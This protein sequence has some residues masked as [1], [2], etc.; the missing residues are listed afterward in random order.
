MS[1]NFCDADA[2]KIID[3]VEDRRL[4]SL[5]KYFSR[6]SRNARLNV[7]NIIIDMYTPYILHIKTM[8]PN[9]NIITD[10]FHTVQLI[11]RALNKTR[12]SLMNKDKLHYNKLKR[13][14]KLLL[15]DCNTLNHF[16]FQKYT[17]FEI[18]DRD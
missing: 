5:T 11:N 18:Y 2:G 3:I 12:I 7:K 9:A 14:W 4:Y 10:K 6:Y 1:F 16:K 15:R 8:F 17:C 13:Y